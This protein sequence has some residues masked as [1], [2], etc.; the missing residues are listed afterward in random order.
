VVTF[1]GVIRCTGYRIAMKRPK[2]GEYAPFHESYLKVLPPRGTA[3]RLLKSTFK[4]A[5]QLLGNLPEAMGDHTYAQGRW[6]IKQVIM[7][8]IDFER[9]FSFR[10]LSFIRADRV[11]LPGFNQDFWMEEVH[12]TDRTI[13]DLLKEWKAVRDNT[14]FL[15]AQC[16]EPQSRFIGMASN[17]KVSVRA[18]FYII[19]GH[20]LHHMQVLQERYGL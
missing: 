1:A 5:Q 16:T 11:A 18:Y 10:I 17:W 12:V 7:H 2:K 6:T 13:K 4:E 15:L 3:Q 19:I 9:V 14:L 20:Q 8:L